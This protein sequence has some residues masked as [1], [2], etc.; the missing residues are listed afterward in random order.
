MIPTYGIKL[1]QNPDLLKQIQA[2]TD[3][4]LKLNL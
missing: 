1:E 4:A 2:E 3:K